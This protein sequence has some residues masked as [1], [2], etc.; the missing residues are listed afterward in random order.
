MTSTSFNVTTVPAHERTLTWFDFATSKERLRESSHVRVTSVKSHNEEWLTQASGTDKAS[1]W[2]DLVLIKTNIN[3]IFFVLFLHQ[4]HFFCLFRHQQ[5]AF[6]FVLTSTTCF[7]FCSDINNMAFVWSD[8]NNMAF[9]F[10]QC[11]QYGCQN[12]QQ[13]IWE[14]EVA[15]RLERLRDSSHARVT[16]LKSQNGKD[17]RSYSG[18]DKARQWSD[19]GLIKMKFLWCFRYIRDHLNCSLWIRKK[20]VKR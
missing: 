4:Q 20:S 9:V 17:L 10:F 12:W 1:K 16:S 11:Q 18:T 2:S 7:L 6:C 14:W 3:N 13:L 5:H 8:I 15:W 19:L